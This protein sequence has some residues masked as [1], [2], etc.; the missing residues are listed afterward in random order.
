MKKRPGEKL[1]PLNPTANPHHN[2]KL[3]AAIESVFRLTHGREMTPD[4]RRLFGI[5]DE[6]FVDGDRRSSSR[7][8]QPSKS[9][10]KSRITQ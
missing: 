6:N 2:R 10:R 5:A 9:E 8:S 7:S 4:E 1:P 3:S